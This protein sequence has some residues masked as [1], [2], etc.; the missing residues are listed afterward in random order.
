[1][2]VGRTGGITLDGR[3]DEAD[4]RKG[5][6]QEMTEISMGPMEN[7]TRFKALYDSQHIILGFECDYDRD[8]RLDGLR[9]FGRDGA[10]YYQEC[11]EVMIDPCG[12]REKHCQFVFNP[13]PD[14]TYDARYGY[15][16]DP[17]HPMY[18]KR[19][20]SWNGEWE[21]AAVID[22]DR[23]RWTAELRIPFTTLEVPPAEP[24]TGWTMNVGRTQFEGVYRKGPMYS[25]W[26]PNLEARSYH[27]RSTFGDMAFE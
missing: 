7:A 16:T 10:A 20:A 19:D 24:G 18:G 22:K 15:I 12:D 11:I 21:Y 6:F 27:D 13:V 25:I 9:S 2:T 1:M 3:L 14:S 26:S 17:I 5:T 8:E 23:K 4:W